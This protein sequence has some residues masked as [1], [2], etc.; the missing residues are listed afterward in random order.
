MREG[1][2]GSISLISEG[3]VG[4]TNIPAKLLRRKD[5]KNTRERKFKQG[6]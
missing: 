3:V 6:F 2:L 4:K 1:I 5:H